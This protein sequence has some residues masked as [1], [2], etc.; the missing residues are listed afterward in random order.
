VGRRRH[1][2]PP[3]PGPARH[4]HLSIGVHARPDEP[5]R[6]LGSGN[7]RPPRATSRP[8]SHPQ[9]RI[10]QQTRR[11]RHRSP[12]PT[13]RCNS[14]LTN[15]VLIDGNA[16]WVRLLD[17]FR[18]EHR[19]MLV[20]GGNGL[21]GIVTPSDMNEQAGRTHLFM[22]ISALEMALSDRARSA[23]EDELLTVLPKDR[24]RSYATATSH[25]A[26]PRSTQSRPRLW[27]LCPRPCQRR[28]PGRDGPFEHLPG[29][30]HRQ[31]H[32]PAQCANTPATR[33]APPASTF[34]RGHQQRGI[35]PNVSTK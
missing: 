29:L 26:A 15:S 10:T 22:Q 8:L 30:R 21:E 20:V 14:G 1:R 28:T 12:H 31:H 11:Q 16:S 6:P 34:R 7:R 17:R 23:P 4:T 18:D 5:A 3:P 19:F 13:A 27:A 24:A 33:V 9:P 32:G 2:R 35:Y 25:L